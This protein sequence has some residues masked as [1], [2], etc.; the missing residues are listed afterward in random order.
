MN[1]EIRVAIIEDEEIFARILATRL[2]DF[3]YTIAWVAAT[4]EEAIIALNKRDYDI[5]MLDIN[6]QTR[7]SGLELGRMI[8]SMYRK[9]F[10]FVTSETDDNV[11]KE[12]VGS[13]PSAYLIKP[14]QPH[15]LS[16]TMQCAIKNFSDKLPATDSRNADND[17]FFVKQGEKYKKLHWANIAFLRSDKN[18]TALFNSSDEME[19]L[20][21]NPLSKTLKYV[22]PPSLQAGFVQVNRAEAVQLTFISEYYKNEVK[23]PYFT[24]TVTETFVDDL[25]K[26]MKIA[27]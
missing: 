12:A 21:R 16:A 8:S 19:Y 9:P 17:I 7:R 2:T 15:T 27:V 5:V 14:F 3:G 18:Y 13:N 4:F 10:I 1:D 22:I 24:F 11:I 26:A 23:T 25:K 6:L 20:I